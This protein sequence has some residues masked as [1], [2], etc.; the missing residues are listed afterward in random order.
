[1]KR[2]L[3]NTLLVFLGI[4]AVFLCLEITL[5]ITGLFYQN[6][7]PL[8]GPKDPRQ[9]VILCIGDSFVYGMGAPPEKSF[10]RQ[11]EEM[12]NRERLPKRVQVINNGIPGMNIDQIY[13]RFQKDVDKIHPDLVVF[14]G[15]W[16]CQSQL[17]G[18]GAFMKGNTLMARLTDGVYSVRTFKFAKYLIGNV[19]ERRRM[20]R[21]VVPARYP[22]Q[23]PVTLPGES[24]AAFEQGKKCSDK[25]DYAG[26][27]EAYN[28]SIALCPRKNP[29][30]EA[31]ARMYEL[32]G[33]N[34]EALA[35]YEKGLREQAPCSPYAYF[36]IGRRYRDNNNFDKAYEMFS[37]GFESSAL[38]EVD[39]WNFGQ[40]VDLYYDPKAHYL[41]GEIKRYLNGMK[42]KTTE[43]FRKTIESL[44]NKISFKRNINRWK[45]KGVNDIID[46][47]QSKK[48]PVILQDYPEEYEYCCE[49]I[50]QKRSVPFV[51]NFRVFRELLKNTPRDKYFVCDGH[52][53]AN[54][55]RVMAQNICAAI[56][57]RGLVK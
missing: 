30:Y 29:S 36:Y 39:N 51:C 50:A 23:N 18:Y 33:K 11:L 2:V 49:D 28:R 27:V 17:N 41:R 42:S 55:Y 25:G 57:N 1:M 38:L 43:D 9:F 16:N 15:G 21:P 13:K 22:W 35:Y 12:L 19:Q 48:I 45:I 44:N 31:L 5:R 26:A 4:F 24:Q 34:A 37:R 7:T 40:L 47:C 20:R 6:P 10:P 54:G 56:I 32:N 53:N 8:P 14:L 3:A 46:L 52:C